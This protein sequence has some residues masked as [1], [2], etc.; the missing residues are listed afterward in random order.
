MDRTFVALAGWKWY[1]SVA[2]MLSRC[3][4]FFA[5]PSVKLVPVSG[6]A[7]AASAASTA[8]GLS[9]VRVLHC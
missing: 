5:A 2:C 4:V 9:N 1:F 7:S 6:S 8:L 3:G